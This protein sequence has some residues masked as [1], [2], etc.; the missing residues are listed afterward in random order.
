[1]LRDF[2]VMGM[3]PPRNIRTYGN[4]GFMYSIDQLMDAAKASKGITSDYKLAKELGCTVHTVANWRHSRSRPDDES[5]LTLAEWAGFDPCLVLA[6]IHASRLTNDRVKTVWAQIAA[7]LEKAPAA[8]AAVIFSVLFS[9]GPDAG[10]QAS[11]LHSQLAPTH[12]SELTA[13]TSWQVTA[14]L[15]ARL[16]N[17]R[18]RQLA[19]WVMQ[20]PQHFDALPFFA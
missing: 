19:R 2:G 14:R 10:A 5:A 9:G 13:Y 1:M 7:R 20:K 17:L 15:I 3:F 11:T 16:L 6:G 4:G 12:I 8:L 18:C